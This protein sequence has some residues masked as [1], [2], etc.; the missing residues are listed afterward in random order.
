VDLAEQ[1]ET[2]PMQTS[3]K[4]YNRN[5]SRY[6][7]INAF[8]KETF[9]MQ[10]TPNMA[11]PMN[12]TPHGGNA[13]MWYNCPINITAV[14]SSYGDENGTYLEIGLTAR[15]LFKG[16]ELPLWEHTYW[17]HNLLPTLSDCYEQLQQQMLATKKDCHLNQ[18]RVDKTLYA[19]KEVLLV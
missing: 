14:V 3:N 4:T 8:I 7:T 2:T 6:T 9:R 12:S 15:Y 18:R 16:N 10:T 11:L 1:Q 13:A 5:N 19:L 17:T